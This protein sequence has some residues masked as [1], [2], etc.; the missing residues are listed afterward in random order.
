MKKKREKPKSGQK[1][2]RSQIKRPDYIEF[3]QQ[4]RVEFITGFHKR[5]LE[6]IK[7]AKRK[8]VEY[9]K[10][11]LKQSRR[12][13]KENKSHLIHDDLITIQK[14]MEMTSTRNIKVIKEEDRMV[15]V[16]VE[17]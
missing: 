16:T 11:E 8:Q 1:Y 10:L 12:E 3:N 2:K 7:E 14:V 13:L 9:A 5:K 6:R 15:E 4:E 17:G